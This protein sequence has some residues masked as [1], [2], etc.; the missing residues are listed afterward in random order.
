MKKRPKIWL[1]IATFWPLAYIFLFLTAILLMF[2]LA[3]ASGPGPEPRGPASILLTMGFVA[4]FI[5]HIF[6]VLEIMALKVFYIVKV[7]KADHLDQNMKIMWMLLLFFTAIFVEPIYWYLHIWKE[8]SDPALPDHP[9]QVGPGVQSSWGR[10]K[11]AAE[12]EA[13]YVPPAQP[14][15]WR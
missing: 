9:R 10:Q 13:A 2:G 4:V 8:K 3:A 1:G 14:P 6:T 7:L 12:R 11:A 15:D 5:L